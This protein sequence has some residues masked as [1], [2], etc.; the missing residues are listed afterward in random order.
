MKN[1]LQKHPLL[2]I[3]LLGFALRLL[4][5]F[6]LQFY[7][8]HQTDRQFLI[9]GDANGY[10]ELGQKIVAGDTY[11]IHEPPRY[12]LRMPGF[13]MVLALTQQI[14]SG[15]LLISRIC[16]ALIGSSCLL[17]VY[18]LARRVYS[19]EVAFWAALGVAFFPMMV[20]YSVLILSETCFA[21]CLLLNL[22][23]FDWLRT[24]SRILPIPEVLLSGCTAALAVSMRPAWILFPVLFGLIWW[25]KS[26]FQR[27][28]FRLS[29][30]VIVVMI[31][32]LL[33]WAWRNHEVT[34]HWVFTTLWSGPS[35]YDGLN[36]DAIGKSNMR[37]FD[38]D[39]LWENLSEYEINQHYQQKAFQFV[40][41]NPGKT[42]QLVFAKQ[43]EFWRP[44]LSA[45]SIS[46]SGL[47]WILATCFLLM[48][49]LAIFAVWTRTF[50][51]WSLF[52]ALAPLFYFAA[53][54][55]FFVGSPRYR[56][57]AEFP[58]MI[59]AAAGWCQILKIAKK[60]DKPAP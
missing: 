32:C 9:E 44:W 48:L 21:A 26:G 60:Q 53:I 13:P 55:A 42:I 27:R 40:T 23:M 14:G 58:L 34:G 19:D 12:V 24:S 49:I 50:S 7:L 29:C 36:P 6:G 33:P 46:H 18:Q 57:P 28:V 47:S 20:G 41:A 38:E 11:A 35:L 56:L 51:A 4:A 22:L 37:F 15:S 30:E 59:L 39:R 3:F 2:L 1:I 10:W 5:A 52:F 17:L 25:L 43:G 31:L 16:L 8:D 45:E 54:H